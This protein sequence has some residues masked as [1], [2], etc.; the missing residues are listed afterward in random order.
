MACSLLIMV[1]YL[2]I[3]ACLLLITACSLLIMACWLLIMVRYLLI[4]ACFFLI[5][6]CSNAFLSSF[7][8]SPASMTGINS[9]R[10]K[11]STWR[12]PPTCTAGRPGSTHPQTH[13]AS[14]GKPCCAARHGDPKQKGQS[15]GSRAMELSHRA[16]GWRVRDL[17]PA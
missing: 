17:A 14:S 9:H 12:T 2:L 8:F 5:M 15:G 10:P 3:M 1:C 13:A 7:C 6:V 4:M 11:M 16:G